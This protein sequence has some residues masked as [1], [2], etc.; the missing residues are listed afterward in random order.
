MVVCA[1]GSP[2]GVFLRHPSELR[3]RSLLIAVAFVMSGC[4]AVLGLDATPLIG[5]SGDGSVPDSSHLVP[6]GTS[7]DASVRDAGVSSDESSV[8]APDGTVTDMEPDTGMSA[9]GGD[10]DPGNQAES[11]VRGNTDGGPGSPPVSLADCVLLMHMD[12]AAWG[13]DAGVVID[14]SGQGNNGTLVG[15]TVQ[16]VE[17]GK[18][19]RAAQFGGSGLI[20]VPD[21][22][23]LNP[24]TA[25]T[26]AAWINPT[27][28]I[29]DDEAGAYYPGILAKREGFDQNSDFAMFLWT[30]DN[31]YSDIENY[32]AWSNAKITAASGW[33]HVAIVYDGTLAD[34]TKRVSIY[35]NGVL[36]AS[37]EADTTMSPHAV[38]LDIG[39]LAQGGYND[40]SGYYVGLIDEVAIWN[41][42]LSAAEI[43]A[44]YSA[45]TPL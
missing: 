19:G 14:S 9:G 12:E 37:G 39:F 29:G 13:P 38:D 17:G 43:A 10:A 20:D 41:R 11:G 2:E 25:L 4:D 34:S 7:P 16:T 15:T 45:T 30:D 42:A 36:D 32:R 6:D 24:T 3:V 8:G 18:F 28:F 44:L 40:P 21:A 5:A 33:T 22:P 31:L 27:G 26:Y 23:S 35:V 1:G